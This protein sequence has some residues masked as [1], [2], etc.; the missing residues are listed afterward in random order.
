MQGQPDAGLLRYRDHCFQ[1]IAKVGPHLIDAMRPFF[2][3]WRQVLDLAVIERRHAGAAPSRLLVVALDNAMRVEVVLDHRQ[4]RASRSTD[5]LA[6]L[7]DLGVAAGPS[8]DG[9][10]PN[11]SSRA[12]HYRSLSYRTAYPRS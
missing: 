4:A 5:R 11:E 9:V 8:I 7:L 2:R 1:E 6:N 3:K 12:I 10:L